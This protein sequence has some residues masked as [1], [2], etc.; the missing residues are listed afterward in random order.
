MSDTVITAKARKSTPTTT[1]TITT[2]IATPIVSPISSFDSLPVTKGDTDLLGNPSKVGGFN[3]TTG[4]VLYSAFLFAFLV[5][6]GFATAKRAQLRKKFRLD[7]EKGDNLD[8]IEAGRIA[9]GGKGM[10]EKGGNAPSKQVSDSRKPLEEVAHHEIGRNAR[11]AE[12][13]AKSRLEANEVNKRAVPEERQEH[14]RNGSNG[15]IR[16]DENV[17]AARSGSLKRTQQQPSFPEKSPARRASTRKNTASPDLDSEKPIEDS[18]ARY[19]DDFQDTTDYSVPSLTASTLDTVPP[20]APRPVYQQA[21]VRPAQSG[22]KRSHTSTTPA[23]RPPRALSHGLVSRSGSVNSQSSRTS[24]NT[25]LPSER[26]P[27][28]SNRYPTSIKKSN[29]SRLPPSMR[30]GTPT[31]HESGSYM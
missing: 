14:S 26:D 10:N 11:L 17:G 27:S 29:S 3:P 6:I 31:A 20:Q 24:A 30:A 5:A 22:V 23:A 13:A 28:D 7:T 1:T 21:A 4:I 25:G 15:G 9:P 16:F 18:I 2:T 12:A 19:E 8:A